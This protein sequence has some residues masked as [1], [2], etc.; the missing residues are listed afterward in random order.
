[1][2]AYFILALAA[3]QAAA[4]QPPLNLTCGGGGTANK[5][6]VA[7]AYGNSNFSYGRNSHIVPLDVLQQVP[8]QQRCSELGE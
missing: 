2:M 7:N 6:A 1:M 8:L 5:L 4:G 3:A